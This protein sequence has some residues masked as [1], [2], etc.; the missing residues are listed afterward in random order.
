MSKL[1]ALENISKL[2]FL[3]LLLLRDAEIDAF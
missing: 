3:L 2:T 1:G